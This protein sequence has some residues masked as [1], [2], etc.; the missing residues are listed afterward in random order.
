M[1]ILRKAISIL[2]IFGL[3][4]LFLGSSGQKNQIIINGIVLSEAQIDEI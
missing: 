4:L 2:G 3:M 1:R